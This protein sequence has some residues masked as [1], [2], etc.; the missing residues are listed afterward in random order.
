MLTTDT[1][2]SAT[3]LP[4]LRRSPALSL[5]NNSVHSVSMSF[6]SSADSFKQPYF[7]LVKPNTIN[8]LLHTNPTTPAPPPSGCVCVCVYTNQRQKHLSPFSVPPPSTCIPTCPALCARS[9][10][11][12]C[13]NTL[14]TSLQETGQSNPNS[15]GGDC[16]Y[17]GRKHPLPLKH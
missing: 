12:E 17:A 1:E 11:M 8:S 16:R 7:L 3:I 13:K 10:P 9:G 4:Y 14:A 2:T 5:H 15:G 6:I